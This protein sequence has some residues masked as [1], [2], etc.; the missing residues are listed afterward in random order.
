MSFTYFME[1]NTKQAAMLN[2][3]GV[4]KKTKNKNKLT[5]FQL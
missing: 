4:L 2:S 3:N 1:R 5:P